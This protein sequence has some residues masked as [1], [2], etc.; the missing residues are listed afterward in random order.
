[1]DGRLLRLAPPFPADPNF[2]EGMNRT[3]SPSPRCCPPP[4]PGQHCGSGRFLQHTAVGPQPAPPEV[5]YRYG[6]NGSKADAWSYGAILF[7]LLAGFM[8]FDRPQ[9]CLDLGLEREKERERGVGFGGSAT[10][11]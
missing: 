10:S 11:V 6:H 1:M 4:T 7:V 9:P 3:W 2:W 5:V 8:P